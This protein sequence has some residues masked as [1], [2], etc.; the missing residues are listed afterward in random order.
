ML[1]W[2]NIIVGSGHILPLTVH[3]KKIKFM[4]NHSKDKL[5]D[6]FVAIAK[7]TFNHD[8]ID[9]TACVFVDKLAKELS[10]I[11]PDWWR[12]NGAPKKV[13]RKN[14]GEE[15]LL[16]NNGTYS[17]KCMIKFR[18]EGHLIQEYN[19]SVFDLEFFRFEY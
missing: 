4:T 16:N 15:F 13:I 9:D 7:L 5:N 12:V 17:N 10:K 14:D 11:D 18:E 3:L 19:I 6:F 1:E 2:I 8:V